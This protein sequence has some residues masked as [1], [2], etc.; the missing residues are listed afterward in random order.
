MTPMVSIG[1]FAFPEPS[2]YSSTTST[3]VDSARNV[4]GYVIGAVIRDGI[5]KI[6]MSWNF[7]TAQDWASIM[8]K[9]NQAQGGAFYNDVTFFL[10]D[11]NSWV[12]K[13]MYV[14]D[15]KAQVFIRNKDGSIKGYQSASLSLVEV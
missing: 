6:E 7:I 2:K 1:S 3:V 9:F 4:K 15:R 8:A 13:Q 12:T 11:T 14:S 5:S 10:Q